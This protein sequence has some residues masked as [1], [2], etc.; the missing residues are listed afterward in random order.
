MTR[1]VLIGAG[2]LGLPSGVERPLVPVATDTTE[3]QRLAAHRHNLAVLM[4]A[5][6]AKVDD[7]AVR[8][9]DR[10]VARARFRTVE[11]SST[12]LADALPAV[13][14]PLTAI[15]GGRDA[16]A[17]GSGERRTRLLST[18]V[19]GCEVAEIAGA[20]HWAMYEE[21]DAVNEL[22]VDRLAAPG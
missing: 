1:L 2:G 5:D 16:F 7:L 17:R 4:I 10:N 12:T 9:H 11:P 20:G 8:L 3:A 15:S 6:P 13:R 21:P 14:A 18:L 22:L 19:P